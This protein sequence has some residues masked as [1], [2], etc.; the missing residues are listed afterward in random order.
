MS[1]PTKQIGGLTYVNCAP[2]EEQESSSRGVDFFNMDSIQRVF[3]VR[4]DTITDF[5]QAFAKDT[6]DKDYPWMYATAIRYA[7]LGILPQATVTFRG[8]SIPIGA[9]KNAPRKVTRRMGLSTFNVT[10]LALDG[11]GATSNVVYK[12]PYSEWKYTTTQDPAIMGPQFAG[13]MVQNNPAALIN[14]IFTSGALGKIFIDTFIYGPGQAPAKPPQDYP[15]VGVV[16]ILPSK[17]DPVQNG[18]LYEVTE[19]NEINVFDW[20][21]FYI[22]Q[23]QTKI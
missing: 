12:A 1:T 5:E 14:V 15:F 9:D 16:R 18:K 7:G 6:P 22:T 20:T 13:K 3:D 21:A 17:F 10:L 4:P 2:W 8:A 11:N 19:R 23:Q